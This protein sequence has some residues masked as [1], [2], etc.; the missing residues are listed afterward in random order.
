MTVPSVPPVSPVSSVPPVSPVLP[1]SPVSPRPA[2]IVLPARPVRLELRRLRDPLDAREALDAGLTQAE[3]SRAA[4][5]ARPRD[6]AAFRV[7]R[8]LVRGR[9]GAALGMAPADVPLVVDAAGRPGCPVPGAPAFSITHCKGLVVVGWQGGLGA[10]PGAAP[11][12][13]VDAE[14]MASAIDEATGTTF[15]SPQERREIDALAPQARSLARLERFVAKEA[16]LKARGTGFI[17]DPTAL[18]LV[19]VAADGDEVPR[20]G[21]R[22][23]RVTDGGLPA[24]VAVTD[25]AGRWLLGVSHAGA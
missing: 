18:H 19:A 9:L 25:L 3:R 23:Y 2:V 20:R 4:R 7:A 12:I 6:A 21:V 14:P 24:T 13:G 8:A 22:R 16:L 15:L 1:V 10:A 5:F 17:A 11:A